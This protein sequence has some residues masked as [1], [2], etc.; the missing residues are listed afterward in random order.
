LLEILGN[1]SADTGA[2]ITPANHA[3]GLYGLIAIGAWTSQLTPV[4]GPAWQAISDVYPF[5]AAAILAGSMLFSVVLPLKLWEI[6]TVGAV[7]LVLLPSA[8]PDYRLIH[9]LIPFA[10]FVNSRTP[11][12]DGIVTTLL[13]ALLFI[14]K[15]WVIIAR[16]VSLNSAINPLILL[17][18]LWR[19]LHAANG[20]RLAD[21]GVTATVPAAAT[22]AVAAGPQPRRR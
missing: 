9:M 21:R 18:L 14:P 19:T 13:F 15:S 1:Y 12:R 5:I 22:A 16:E 8:S 7:C 3:S 11:R 6:A 2:G 17:W 20:R 4:V 10:L